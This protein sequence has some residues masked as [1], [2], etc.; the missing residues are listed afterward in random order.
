[1]NGTRLPYV[2]PKYLAVP[3][4]YVRGSHLCVARYPQQAQNNEKDFKVGAAA[5]LKKSKNEFFAQFVDS[6]SL[7][8][9]KFFKT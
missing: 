7:G 8:G 9:Q 2:P 5:A 1:M 4:A 6:E 3:L